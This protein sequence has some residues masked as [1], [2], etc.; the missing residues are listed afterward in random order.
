MMIS[1]L[2][3]IGTACIATVCL[4]GLAA[5]AV[6]ETARP[7][8]P[9]PASAEAPDGEYVAPLSQTTQPSY[10]PQSVALSGPR[11][12]RDWHEGDEIPYGYHP[13]TRMRMGLMITGA[14]VLGGFYLYSGLIASAAS[15]VSDSGSTDLTAL[16]LPVLGPFVAMAQT[17][18]ATGRYLL[19]I[20]GLA[21]SAGAFMLIYAM[22]SPKHVLVRNDLGLVT[23]V[24]M[25][26][27]NDGTGIGVMG[28][29]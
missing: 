21:Q 16:Y 6:A 27:A 24:P 2:F 18:S 28:R 19:A 17:E 5:P 15:D 3:R 7:S 4:T 1:N 29:F 12:I 26:L 14:A 8:R 25:R 22:T 23:V 20:D 11:M 9:P 13:E 10:V